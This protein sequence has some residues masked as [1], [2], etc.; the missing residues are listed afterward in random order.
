MLTIASV[1]RR[2]PD[3]RRR[4]ALTPCCDSPGT[5]K[6]AAMTELTKGER[7]A[8]ERLF[9]HLDLLD[10]NRPVC[11]ALRIC[12]KSGSAITRSGFG[13]IGHYALDHVRLS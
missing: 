5:E 9:K 11:C 2:C 6:G 10:G 4:A 12:G 1:S 3:R 8:R 7:I 13:L